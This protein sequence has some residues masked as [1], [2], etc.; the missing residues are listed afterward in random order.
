MQH[1]YCTECQAR[2]SVRADTCLLGH[3]IDPET[4]SNT[5]GRR[6]A[7]HPRRRPD[8]VLVG[9]PGPLTEA[10]PTIIIAPPPPVVRTQPPAPAGFR[11]EETRFL[12]QDLWNTA[13]HLEEWRDHLVKADTA[14]FDDLPAHRRVRMITAVAM[15]LLGV[16]WGVFRIVSNE[17]Q[18]TFDQTRL[19]ESVASLEVVLAD[20][21]DGM[22]ID[23]L[24]VPI[25]IHDV[26]AVAKNQY[27]AAAT[28]KDP[29]A[30]AKAAA[31]AEKILQV[32]DRL[33][34]VNA[35]QAALGPYLVEPP[36]PDQPGPEDLATVTE[37]LAVWQVDL[38]AAMAL[39][40]VTDVT[41][42]HA[43][44]MTDF[45]DGFQIWKAG[46]LDAVN[47]GQATSRQ[48]GELSDRVASLR[49]D[50]DQ[51]LRSVADQTRQDLG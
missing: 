21:A 40:P 20:F 27:A 32:T 8:A 23:Q 17:P 12:I 44:A 10:S 18:T 33:A 43:R 49:H 26:D 4:I 19:D 35:Y 6:V 51:L 2:V 47:N 29:P 24:T 41:A 13:E 11:L 45:L 36:L 7:R 15:V 48:V 38:E 30:R 34:I 14:A 1:A 16:G 9:T 42:T 39:V 28:I 31:S 37:I 5:R 3:P 22:P 46:Y 50:L 25:A